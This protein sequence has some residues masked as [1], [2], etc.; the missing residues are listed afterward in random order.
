MSRKRTAKIEMTKDRISL[1][2]ELNAM[3]LSF[4]MV[5]SFVNAPIVWAILDNIS[6]FDPSSV[7][8]ESLV[9][10]RINQRKYHYAP[11]RA[12]M[13][14]ADRASRCRCRTGRKSPVHP[15]AR[16]RVPRRAGRGHHH[17][18]LLLCEA[19]P[20]QRRY[21]APDGVFCGH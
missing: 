18:K 8:T 6:C 9:Q 3:F 16:S 17:D 10:P 5:L 1:I 15:D 4:H 11:E 13:Q 14:T 7:T 2:L 12:M 19:G 21:A 20:Q